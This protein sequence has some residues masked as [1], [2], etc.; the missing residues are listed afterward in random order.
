MRY[1]QA[2]QTQ[3]TSHQQDI[4]EYLN[5]ALQV[6]FTKTANALVL[7]Q[8][9]QRPEATYLYASTLFA[10]QKPKI[11][12]KS[13]ESF[14]RKAVLTHVLD[15]RN[16]MASAVKTIKSQQSDDTLKSIDR[17]IKAQRHNAS[18]CHKTYQTILE[19]GPFLKHKETPIAIKNFLRFSPE[20]LTQFATQDFDPASEQNTSPNPI[21]INC[22]VFSS[23]FYSQLNQIYTTVL[24]NISAFSNK[25]LSLFDMSALS[26]S[27]NDA[28]SS[29]QKIEILSRLQPATSTESG[30]VAVMDD[31]VS[32]IERQAQTRVYQEQLIYTKIRHLPIGGV[33][34]FRHCPIQYNAKKTELFLKL[35]HHEPEYD[36]IAFH[37]EHTGKFIRFPLVV[38]VQ[39]YLG[40]DFILAPAIPPPIKPTTWTTR[41]LQQFK[42]LA[43]LTQK[44]LPRLSSSQT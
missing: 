4:Y 39:A 40:G 28:K 26:S 10:R 33:Y 20:A 35:V 9:V 6:S 30:Q 27:E 37:N 15:L 42:P 2:T 36:L 17:L 8:R 18:L 1:V 19:Q 14:I 44:L 22:L 43:K 23:F 29:S 16:N 11:L 32:A 7:M 34:L 13:F 3:S 12:K 5:Q 41:L 31:N 25:P 24:D 38:L 21:A